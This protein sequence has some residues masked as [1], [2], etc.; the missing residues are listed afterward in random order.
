VVGAVAFVHPCLSADS[1]SD[2]EIEIMPVKTKNI[3]RYALN[4]WLESEI[5][6]RKI[7]IP[8]ITVPLYGEQDFYFYRR[9]KCAFYD[10][11]QSWYKK[12]LVNIS[13]S[14]E[15][16]Y[17]WWEGKNNI[18]LF[19]RDLVINLHDGK[20]DPPRWEGEVDYKYGFFAN[21]YNLENERNLKMSSYWAYMPSTLEEFRKLG[22][23]GFEKRRYSSIFI[24]SVENQTQEF[25]REKFQ[26]WQ[27]EIE[28][29]Q[30]TDRLNKKEKNAYTFE[31]Y[32]HLINQSK[33]GV[34]F[35]GNGPKCYREIEYLS[36]GIP[37][38]ITDG[39]EVNYPDPLIEGLH[40]FYA[41]SKSDIKKIIQQASPE[42]WEKMSLA[43][44]DWYEKNASIESSFKKLKSNIEKLDTKLNRHCVVKIDCNK[45]EASAS[46]AFKTLRIF[47]PN[48]SVVFNDSD[49]VL[50][51]DPT[52]VLSPDE[53]VINE[54]P[55]IGKENNYM[56]KITQSQIHEHA[57]KIEK[58]NLNKNKQLLS[59]WGYRFMNF[60]IQLFDKN[61]KD[62]N[63]NLRF[64]K[65]ASDRCLYLNKSETAVLT[66][67]FD[68]SRRCS[69][70]YKSTQKLITG[71]CKVKI[72][73]I[74][75]N[76]VYK[77]FN[78]IYNF[79]LS[80]HFNDYFAI[81]DEI[82]P[83]NLIFKICKLWEFEDCDIKMINGKI[84]DNEKTTS[85]TYNLEKK[86]Q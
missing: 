34:C 42:E 25:F 17:F 36:L 33:F 60:N 19:D 56:W 73:F 38:I 80:K 41:E 86:I 24:G 23:K 63:K 74:E 47:E 70:K 31:E 3:K 13:H 61:N 7:E 12:G 52:L 53:V 30:V 72:P 59:L 48:S 68:W 32:I 40:Y 45:S 71:P 28:F 14:N 43:C 50:F 58:S 10:L 55:F 22:R 8:T 2:V 4:G 1:P 21:E 18:L 11:V 77:K 5:N 81:Y 57:K 79:N 78:E 20:K 62:I 67:D 44:W 26:D 29:Y 16:D 85:F 46:M 84:T 82:I 75:A 35:R 39:V 6:K 49:D 51:R 54:L 76:L 15:A 64:F 66:S 9:N 37:L 69:V 83:E 65:Q 27:D